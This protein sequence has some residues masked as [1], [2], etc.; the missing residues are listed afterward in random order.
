MDCVEI[1]SIY[2]HVKLVVYFFGNDLSSRC[3]AAREGHRYLFVVC[4]VL[5]YP[6]WR[7]SYTNRQYI[8]LNS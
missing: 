2:A 4:L 5:D 1:G 3:R 7:T 8:V 6:W